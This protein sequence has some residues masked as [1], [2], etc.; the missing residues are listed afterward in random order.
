MRGSEENVC[1]FRGAG[2]ALQ[3]GCGRGGYVVAIA[4]ECMGL[5]V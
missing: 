3:S 1:C 5:C 4:V 2:L